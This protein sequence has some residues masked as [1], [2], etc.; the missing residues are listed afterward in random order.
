MRSIIYILLL[1][2][3]AAWASYFL[4]FHPDNIEIAYDQ[5]VISMPLWLP[6]FGSIGVLVLLMVVNTI[7]SAVGGI[8][9]RLREWITGSN[10]RA[11][12][13]NANQ[14]WRELAEGDWFRAETKMLK[15]AK[16]TD[17][18]LH[19]YLAAA[20]AAQEQDALDRRDSYLHLALRM[21]PDAKVAVGIIQASLQ[22][23]QGQYEYAL[24]TVQSLQK[25]APHNREVLRL[26]TEVYSALEQWEEIIK[27]LPLLK[28]YSVVDQ[29]EFLA[30]EIDAYEHLL[31][32]E[33]KNAGKSALVASW[34][35]L[36]REMRTQPDLV[37][38]YTALLIGLDSAA[39]AEQ[40]IRNTLKKQWDQNLVKLYGFIITPDLGKQITTGEAWLKTH[41]NDPSLLLALARLCIAH[42]LWGKARNYLE[43]SLNLEANP[44]AYA[45][46][47]R[48][49][50]FLGDQQ[51]AME[52][53][54]N[55][56]LE[57]ASIL[58]IEPSR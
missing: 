17:T 14:A 9:G 1:V 53:Y 3:L 18:S 39:E 6:V 57:Y 19:Y 26:A 24:A 43:S 32:S 54:K 51:K 52:C 33:A 29:E 34:D 22:I 15:A 38:C 23:Q 31:H 48:L 13:R 25:D 8:F 36:P 10:R 35:T 55:G 44:D 30:L 21:N 56:L 50:G 47:G 42:K 16:S 40:I 7:L 12:E 4:Y 46:L 45:E 41:P 20:R 5:W 28:K 11:I 27:I 58:E 2:C 37:H 49:L